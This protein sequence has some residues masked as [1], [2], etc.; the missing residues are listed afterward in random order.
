MNTLQEDYEDMRESYPFAEISVR[1]NGIYGT[2]R[3]NNALFGMGCQYL[4][5][6]GTNEKQ[7]DAFFERMER[8]FQIWML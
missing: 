7:I 5:T 2:N 4:L 6:F 3:V 1:G 8:A